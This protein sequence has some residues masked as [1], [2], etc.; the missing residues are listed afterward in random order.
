ML[1]D[2]KKPALVKTRTKYC[3]SDKRSKVYIP[4]SAP[5]I[6]GMGYNVKFRGLLRYYMDEKHVLVFDWP[7]SQ[8]RAL[9]ASRASWI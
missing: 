1:V 8:R 3:S 4:K 7:T 5:I 9:C 6:T 2:A